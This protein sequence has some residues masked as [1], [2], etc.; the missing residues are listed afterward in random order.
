MKKTFIKFL[1]VAVSMLSLFSSCEKPT[2]EPEVPGDKN[3]PTI[4]LVKGTAT[5][6]ALNFTIIPA[7]A[8]KCSYYYAKNSEDF[9]EPDAETILSTGT[10][11]AEIKS[12]LIT[13]NELEADTEYVILAAVSN[14]HGT[15]VS[16][17]ILIRTEKV[18]NGSTPE[19][20]ITDIIITDRSVTFTINPL[21]A[22]V[23][24]YDHML[25]TEDFIMPDAY[26]AYDVMSGGKKIDAIDS[27]S[28]ITIDGLRDNTTYY[29]FAAVEAVSSYDKVMDYKEIATKKRPEPEDMPLESFSEGEV[30]YYLHGNKYTVEMT[31]DN[32]ELKFDITGS[33]TNLQYMPRLEVGDYTYKKEYSHDEDFIIDFLSSIKD[34]KTGD[35]LKL[36]KG[37][38]KIEYNAPNYKIT[39]R[40]VTDEDKA[41]NLEFNGELEFPFNASTGSL[42]EVNNKKV[43]TLSDDYHDLILNFSGNDILGT[44]VIGTDIETTSSLIIKS[45]KESFILKSGSLQIDHVENQIY[46]IKGSIILNNN[47]LVYLEIE[48]LDLTIPDDPTKNEI[49]F[50]EA[51]AQGG[52]DGTGYRSAYVLN[53]ECEGWDFEIWFDS[54]GEYDELP[55]GNFVYASWGGGDIVSVKA[56]RLLPTLYEFNDIDEGNMK[57]TKEGNTYTVTLEMLRS[58]GDKLKGSYTGEIECEDMSEYGY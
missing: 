1:T 7:N 2:P 49:T 32:Y 25:K 3:L 35:K 40:I 6:E 52:P 34:K 26:T 24:A 58:N 37:G 47:D 5:A 36:E 50:T 45:S 19:V 46:K 56:K 51:D 15:V 30:S 11:L 13:I 20:K 31:N 28:T 4:S 12:Q 14:E 17:K 53:L 29:I 42:V 57:I 21:N 27:P 9:K 22:S 41:F 54:V 33:T 43:L 16:E 39:G 48:S 38:I 18:A 10:E 55:T 23:V 44:K 8:K